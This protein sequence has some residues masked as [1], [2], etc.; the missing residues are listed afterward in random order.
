MNLSK[1][2]CDAESKEQVRRMVVRTIDDLIQATQRL[3]ILRQRLNLMDVRHDD[4][5][6]DADLKEHTLALQEM[7]KELQE[8]IRT[9]SYLD[10]HFDRSNQDAN[11]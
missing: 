8:A 6:T 3:N 4:F 9:G 2:E 7:A 10:Q 1:F 11:P 5:C